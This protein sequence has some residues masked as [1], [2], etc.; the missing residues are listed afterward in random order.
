MGSSQPPQRDKERIFFVRVEVVFCDALAKIPEMAKGGRMQ[1]A[2]YAIQD[3][4]TEF[5]LLEFQMRGKNP[6][7]F[8]GQNFSQGPNSFGSVGSAGHNIP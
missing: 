1:I 5:G 7:L 4:D 8:I 2:T 3:L 6:A